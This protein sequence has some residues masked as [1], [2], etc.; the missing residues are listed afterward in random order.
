VGVFRRHIDGLTR[1][2][3]ALE[4]VAEAPV[5]RWVSRP[6]NIGRASRTGLELELKGRARDLLTAWVAA[7]SALQLRGSLSVYRSAVEQI[8]DPDARLEG[9]PPWQATL[10]FDNRLAQGGLS[11]GANMTVTPGF[12]IQQTDRQRIWRG[13]VRRLDAF[14]AWRVDAQ[15]QFRFGAA[16]L[17]PADTQSFSSVADLDG[18]TAS[19]AARRETVTQITANAVLRF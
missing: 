2:R 18:F 10:G 17:F 3:I 16:N 14:L 19:N 4:T 12:S 5:P 11:Y 6:A 8:D 15:L 7:D 1:R 13:A 9:Q